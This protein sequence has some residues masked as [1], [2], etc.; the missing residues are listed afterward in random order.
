MKSN[1]HRETVMNCLQCHNPLPVTAN[2][3]GKCGTT[4]P[5]KNKK[6]VAKELD[7]SEG[8]D[9]PIK[10]E[11]IDLLAYVKHQRTPNPVQS[12]ADPEDTEQGHPVQERPVPA[13]QA[14]TVDAAVSEAAVQLMDDL[15]ANLRIVLDI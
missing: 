9:A 6:S 1:E 14:A 13:A 5:G 3:C 8:A 4:V 7:E 15:K 2:F 11:G 12:P 10:E